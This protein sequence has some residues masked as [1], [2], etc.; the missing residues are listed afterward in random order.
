VSAPNIPE[1]AAD[2]A[3]AVVTVVAVTAGAA[4]GTRVAPINPLADDRA[5]ATPAPAVAVAPVR[6][7]A[8]A[9]VDRYVPAT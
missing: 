5:N 9:D 1:V 2:P 3:P 6:S 8:I 4:L 7:D